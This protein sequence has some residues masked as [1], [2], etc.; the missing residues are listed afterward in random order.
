MIELRT[1]ESGINPHGQK[2][3]YFVILID[4]ELMSEIMPE[5]LDDNKVEITLESQFNFK[6]LLKRFGN[7]T[8]PKLVYH[9]KK[10]LS[11][12]ISDF[13]IKE[14]Y[15]QW[16]KSFLGVCKKYVLIILMEMPRLV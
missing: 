16:E 9:E 3:E 2:Y 10:S 12:F 7:Y 14:E 5:K 1:E 8:I 6:K 15:Y 4:S 13:S 11:F